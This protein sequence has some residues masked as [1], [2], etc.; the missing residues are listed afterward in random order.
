MGEDAA[1]RVYAEAGYRVISRNWRCR[2]GELDLVLARGATLVFCE[3]KAR[4]SD[5]FGGGWESVTARK[6]AKVR[7][8]AQAFLLSTGIQADAIRF[9]VASVE[10]GR[11]PGNVTVELFPDAF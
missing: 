8:V 4:R 1:M 11:G 3:V 10:V 9:D 5:A 7:A 6:K 2:I